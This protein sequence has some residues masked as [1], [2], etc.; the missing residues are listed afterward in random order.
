MPLFD[1]RESWCLLVQDN[2]QEGIIDV[3][4]AVVLDEAQFPEF[5]H[6][7]IDP[8]PRRANHLRQHLLRYFGQHLLRMALRAIA[9]E[10]QERARQAFLGRVEELVYQVLLDSYVSRKHISDEAVGEL[11]FLV[12]RANH[13]DFLNDEHGGRCNRDRSRHANGLARKAPFSQEIT[14][15]K[16]RHNSFFSGLIDNGELYTPFLKVHHT[17][18]RITLRVDLPRSSIFHN[19]SGY[20]GSFGFNAA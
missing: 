8:G 3:D 18:G 10:Q 2:A 13:L 15:S 9:R 5:V 4:L 14:R 7:K 12:E 6:E 19:S 11:V 20:T 1:K 17:R 16:D